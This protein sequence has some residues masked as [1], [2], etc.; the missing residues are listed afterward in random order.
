MM[1]KV[2]KMELFLRRN[3]RFSIFPDFPS[4][5]KPNLGQ[6]W[7][8]IRTREMTSK[9]AQTFFVTILHEKEPGSQCKSENFENVFF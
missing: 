9:I 1:N 5:F 7:R 8:L 3:S 6:F 4:K 2:V